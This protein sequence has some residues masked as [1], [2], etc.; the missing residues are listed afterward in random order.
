M[1]E[2]ER[3]RGEREGTRIKA[4]F[5]YNIAAVNACHTEIIQNITHLVRVIVHG[6][7]IPSLVPGGGKVAPFL[8]EK[9]N[10][11]CYPLKDTIL[12]TKSNNNNNS[13]NCLS[14]QQ[15]NNNNNNINYLSQQEHNNNNSL[16]TCS[17]Q[18]T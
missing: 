17:S 14:Q 3:G 13:I 9:T 6:Q 16:P 2:V 4:V 18:S 1:K 15:H 7:E 11:K 10:I 5:V 12:K 8:E